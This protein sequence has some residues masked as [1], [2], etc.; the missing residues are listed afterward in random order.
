MKVSI[1]RRLLLVVFICWMLPVVLIFLFFTLSYRNS[2]IEKK[3]MLMEE[4]AKNYSS[5]YAQKLDEVITISKKISY[6]GNLERAWANYKSN[7]ITDKVIYKEVIDNLKGKYYY[8]NRFDMSVF[9]LIDQPEKVYYTSRQPTYFMENYYKNVES[10]AKGITNQDTSEAQIKVINGEIYIIRN[11]YTTT[12]YTKFG[13]LVLALNKEK[14]FSNMRQNDDYEMAFFINDTDSVVFGKGV[15]D[16]AEKEDTIKK[17]KKDYNKNINQYLNYQEDE[18]STSLLYQQKFEDYHM[19]TILMADKSVIYSELNAVQRIIFIIIII[20]IPVF[21][22][23][24]YFIRRHIS[25]PISKIIEASKE[26]ESGHLGVQMEEQLMPNSEFVFIMHS[27]N[28][29]SAKIKHIVDYAYQE[30]IAKKEAKIIALQSQINPHF[31]NNTLEMMNWQARLAGDTKVTKM[32]ESLATLLDYTMDRSNHQLI[33]LADELRCV[34]AYLYL[35]SMRFGR[36]LRVEREIDNTLLYIKVPQLILQPIIEN[37]VVHGVEVVKSGVIKL[38]IFRENDFCILQVINTGENMT[39]EDYMRVQAILENDK[40]NKTDGEYVSLGIRNVNE[41]IKLIYG[42]RYGL[43]ICP[44]S[45]GET[46]STITIPCE[47][48]SDSEKEKLLKNII[49]HINQE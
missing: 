3:E 27:F 48:V 29:I 36:R 33:N 26:I 1:R 6:D 11:L 16:S 28:R 46:A 14:L 38:K 41:R 21:F 15:I 20:I 8:D 42:D 7:T 45:K 49:E 5:L 23:M 13:T 24:V 43:T 32:I 47:V 31:L 18:F 10:V 22:Y 40:K 37:A 30:E 35:A 2:I 4:W 34:D 19:G 25:T 39:A 9:Y 17:L 44:I 12:N